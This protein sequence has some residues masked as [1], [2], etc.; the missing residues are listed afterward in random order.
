[1]ATLRLDAVGARMVKKPFDADDLVA[2]LRAAAEQRAELRLRGL[3]LSP[4]RRNTT[5]RDAALTSPSMGGGIVRDHD[6]LSMAHCKVI[7][8]YVLRSGC[9]QSLRT[10]GQRSL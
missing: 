10:D 1:M 2:M 3:P 8:G 9:A 7:A 4:D 5:G 6:D